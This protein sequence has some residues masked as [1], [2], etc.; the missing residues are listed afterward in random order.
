M[1]S[2]AIELFLKRNICFR[3][4]VDGQTF[5]IFPSLILERP[6]R[7]TEDKEL[8]DDTAFVVTGPVE[9]LYPALVVL[10]GYSPSFQR[11]NQWR[12]QAQYETIHHY[13]CGFRQTNDE[14]GELELVL[15]YGR[16]T[17]D[18]FRSRFQ[19]LFEEI[20]YTHSHNLIV[21]KYPPI[22]CK[23]CGRQQERRIVIRRMQE[24]KTFLFCDEDGQKVNLPKT[25]KR[26]VLSRKVHAE[27]TADQ[28]LSQMRTTYEAALVR[29]K[30][31]AR[32]WFKATPTCFISYAWG[33]TKHERWVLK[34]SDDLRKADIVVTLDQWNNSMVGASISRYASRIEQSDFIIVVGT[35]SYR[36]KYEIKIHNMEVWLQQK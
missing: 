8:I 20:L 30:G 1:L 12:N 19:G 29:V 21:Q 33:N 28:A 5:L 31:F 14:H 9:N 4:S 35:S 11:T 7:L 13:I 6:P 23:K 17:P 25:A 34:L 26:L 16:N 15:Y 22:F 27:V 24:G 32:D 2:A 3:E 18:F 36:Q 10:L